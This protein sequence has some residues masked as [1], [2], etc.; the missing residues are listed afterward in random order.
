MRTWKAF[1]PLLMLLLATA[2]LAEGRVEETRKFSFDG[3]VSIENIAGSVRVIGWDREQIEITAD[4]GRGTRELDIDGDGDHIDIE[5]V[6]PSGR[7]HKLEGSELTIRVP[8]GVELDVETISASVTVED[9]EG[10][11]SVESVNGR[12]SISGRMREVSVETVSGRIEVECDGLED[13][14]FE[15]VSGNITVKGNLD[16]RGDFTLETLSG[17]VELWVPRGFS[18]D[19]EIETFSGT[20]DTDFG[21]RPDRDSWLGTELEFSVG[22]GDA[23]VTLSSFSGRIRLRER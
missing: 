18:A 7:H 6:L 16:P 22:A 19:Y 20:I 21:P 12:V 17:S 14:E 15:S 23:D 13:G 2:A 5:V 9:L 10:S 4:L 1:T 8:R 3:S 11:V